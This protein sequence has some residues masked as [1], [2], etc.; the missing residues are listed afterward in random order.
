MNRVTPRTGHS[1]FGVRRRVNVCTIQVLGMAAEAGVRALPGI[2]LREGHDARFASMRGDVSGP[3]P[4]ATL[5]SRIRGFFFAAR[6]AFKMRIFVELEPD[7]RV[8]GS[9]GRAADVSASLWGFC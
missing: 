7:I 8:T 5:T 2:Q 9:A 6:D 1:V 4:M 3:W